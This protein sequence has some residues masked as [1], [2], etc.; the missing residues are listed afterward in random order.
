MFQNLFHSSVRLCIAVAIAAASS[1][2][3]AATPKPP[4]TICIDG[5]CTS[6]ATTTVTSGK[7]KYHPGNYVWFAP[8][9]C[10]SGD[11][12][13]VLLG[14]RIDRSCAKA[15]LK[16]F[17]QN[18][19]FC[20]DQNIKG[21]QVAFWWRSWEGNT[22]GDFAHGEAAFDDIIATAAAC[23]KRVMLS[24]WTTVFGGW[25]GTA[26]GPDVWPKYALDLSGGYAQFRDQSNGGCYPNGGGHAKVWTQAV[27]DELIRVYQHY[28]A[29][30][31]G[32][33]WVEMVTTPTESGVS[34]CD[35]T[36]SEDA[37]Y[38]QTKRIVTGISRAWP[39]TIVRVAANDGSDA[40]LRDLFAHLEAT[41][42]GAVGGPDIW[43]GDITT[44]D[45]VYAGY[46]V[47]GQ[48]SYTDY[49]DRLP[50][51]VEIQWQ[52]YNLCNSLGAYGGCPA[53]GVP[54]WSLQTLWNATN[55][56]YKPLA[57]WANPNFF[58]P[59]MKTKY[60]IWLHNTSNGNSANQWGTAQ[61]A[62][63]DANPPG[64]PPATHN[65]N[66]CPT[67]YASCNTG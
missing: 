4:A 21:I 51:A 28:G 34:T 40:N 50:W 14:Y 59:S 24:M 18:P 35:S 7:I 30:Y 37:L 17:I 8:G 65:I 66:A 12:G 45:R 25:G 43:P 61:Q 44:A 36:Y 62:F 54:I 56:G 13:G 19:S 38:T 3:T 32:N 9:A 52:S 48:Q 49:R 23:K 47:S 29:R 42:Q 10:D 15:Q 64:K 16:T 58:L 57:P 60:M 1:S 63:L 55:I 27:A 53:L 22:R 20:N 39:N 31:N 33:P 26:G 2:V 11:G 5:N 67:S 6:T 46:N 41:G